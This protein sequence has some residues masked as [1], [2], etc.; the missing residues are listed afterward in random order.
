MKTSK[1][2]LGIL[3]AAGMVIFLFG[4]ED[5]LNQA[6]VSVYSDYQSINVP[7]DAAP[8][9]EYVFLNYMEPLNLDSMMSAS[10]Y[11]NVENVSLYEAN[12][13]LA[14]TSENQNF[15]SFKSFQILLSGNELPEVIIAELTDIP[16]NVSN[17]NLNTIDIDLLQY[18]HGANY[19]LKI[20]GVLEEDLN[21]P[22]EIVGRMR[23]K[24]GFGF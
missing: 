2:F 12:L 15:N 9:G 21:S 4:C 13:S 7:I 18:M 10:G 19:E 14:D 22:I 24:V 6:G 17:I 1:S 3:I 8:A 11:Q 20:K 5:F 23:Y 16:E